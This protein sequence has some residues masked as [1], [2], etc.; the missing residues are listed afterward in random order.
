MISV[1]FI[2]LSPVS[3]PS[4]TAL[5]AAHGFGLPGRRVAFARFGLPS[6]VPLAVHSELK[7][8]E[9]SRDDPLA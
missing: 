2:R 1:L 6:E 7:F 5:L 8:W 9:L 3:Q 4:I